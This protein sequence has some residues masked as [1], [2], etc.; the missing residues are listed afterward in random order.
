MKRKAM[1]LLKKWKSDIDRK[2]FVLKGARQVGKTWL[3]KSF[4]EEC[5]NDY[6]YINFDAEEQISSIFKENKDPFRIVELLGMIKGKRIEPLKHLIILDE[7]QECPEALN[8]LKYF[9]ENANDYHII[10]AGSLLGTLL[11]QPKSYPV[12][13]VN[14]LNIYPLSFEEFL[15]ANDEG[16]YEYYNSI[17]RGSKIESIFHNKL[18]DM[19][20][21]Y[22]I[23]GGMPECV[24][25]W[26]KNKDASKVLSIQK[27]LIELYENDF[28]KHNGKVN[29]GRILLVFRSIVNQLAKD[30]SKFIYGCVREGARAREFEEAIEWLVSAGMVIRIH[31]VS[32]P[33][34]PLNAY[35]ENNHF[36][37]FMFDVGLLKCM[38]GVS[39][40]AILL[41]SE[42]QFKGAM[43]ENYCVQ[44]LRD[45]FDTSL[46]YYVQSPTSE[47]DLI[48][49]NG[50]EIIPMEI[51]AGNSLKSNSFKKYI[52]EYVPKQ[53]IRFSG[54]EYIEQECVINVPLYLA[55]KVKGMMRE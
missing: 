50:M 16:L 53:A 18:S 6:I 12:G 25:N 31:N 24:A 8:T 33:E 43:A 51:K 28:S 9:C 36:K 32:K 55:G 35:E 13:K 23:I 26:L 11:A 4:G 52:S 40:E 14:I 44:Q 34:H 29:S 17:H 20:K 22:L 21:Q 30:N 3:M 54:Q 48:V 2:P 19:Y 37:L 47:I 39:N 7:I 45:T 15:N 10:A 38:A 49:Q 41:N 1:D 46:K 5:Y 27:E 42:F